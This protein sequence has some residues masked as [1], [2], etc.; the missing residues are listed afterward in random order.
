MTQLGGHGDLPRRRRR[1]ARRSARRWATSPTTWSG[2]SRAS[3]PASPPTTS[4]S[5]S[6]WRPPIPV[7]NALTLREH[8]C[9]AL[10]DLLTLRERFGRL[11]GLVLTFVGDGNNVFHSL[12]LAGAIFGLEVRLAHPEGYGPDPRIVARATGIA[13]ATGG[14]IVIGHDPREMVRGAAVLYTDSWTSMG[15]EAETA[16]RRYAFATYRIDASLLEA[17]GPGRARHALPARAPRRGDQ[18]RGHGRAAQPHLGPV[19]EPAPRPEGPAR[20]DRGSAG[21]DDRDPLRALQGRPA[22]RP[23]RRPPGHGRT[24]RSA[25]MPRRSR[26]PPTGRSPTSAGPASS[27]RSAGSTRRWPATSAP[28]GWPRATWRRSAAGPRPWLGSAAGRTRPRRSTT[29]PTLHEAA[30]RTAEACDTARRALEQ[31]ESKARRRHIEE[32]TRIK[33]R[34]AVGDK[35]AEQ[36]LARALHVLEGSP[37]RCPERPPPPAPRPLLPWLPA[38]EA[39]GAGAGGDGGRPRRRRPTWLALAL[40]GGGGAGRGRRSRRP[41]TGSSPLAAAHQAAGRFAAALDACYGALAVAPADTDLHLALV[42]PV[43]GPRLARPGGRQAGPARPPDRAR[44]RRPGPRAALLGHRGALPGRPEAGRRSA[45]EGLRTRLLADPTDAFP[46]SRPPGPAGRAAEAVGRRR[47]AT[48]SNDVPTRPVDPRPGPTVDAGRCRDHRAAHL[49]AVQPDPRDARRPPRHRRQRPV[50]GLRGGPGVRAATPLPDPPDRGRRRPVRARR[51]LPARAA[52]GP[53]ADRPG[54]LAGLAHLAG[55]ATERRAGRRHRGPGGRPPVGR[56]S[57][58]A[59]R[60]RAR[61]RARGDRR[62]RAS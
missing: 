21:R 16:V 35:A 20:R 14:R 33:L 43:P 44:R 41:A 29:S 50:P 59:H 4:W 11:E 6:R 9:Q 61:D 8:P 31:A 52:A 39:S 25:P 3:W 38:A 13:A 40:R 48:L 46:A 60:A 22:P 28:C 10:A 57:R 1:G 49:L 47:D 12:A 26:S 34:E 62:D 54:G 45:P 37:R 15:Q 42:G 2:S 27:S 55:R 23:R 53:R 32:L 24:R 18:R 36:A 5:S 58:R 56:R 17:A 19:R 7:I 30:G 51:R